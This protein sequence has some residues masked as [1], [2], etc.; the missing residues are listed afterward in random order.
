LLN[1]TAVRD[2]V[3]TNRSL[4]PFQFLPLG[5]VTLSDKT[6]RHSSWNIHFGPDQSTTL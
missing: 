2:T 5:C 1:R 6:N 4:F 3:A